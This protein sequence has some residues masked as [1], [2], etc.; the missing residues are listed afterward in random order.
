M[1]WDLGGVD[2]IKSD[3]RSA[4]L[5]ETAWQ[6]LDIS[7]KVGFFFFFKQRIGTTADVQTC[8]LETSK[9]YHDVFTTG[10]EGTSLSL[11]DSHNENA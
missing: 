8:C 10:S 2:K 9:S 11:V 7:Q 5:W 3:E 4:Y 6:S 1:V